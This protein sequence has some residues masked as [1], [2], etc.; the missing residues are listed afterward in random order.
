M[1]L[2]GRCKCAEWRAST[3]LRS[4][5]ACPHRCPL[6]LACRRRTRADEGALQLRSQAVIAAIHTTPVATLQRRGV[7][8]PLLLVEY[9]S[10]AAYSAQNGP[11]TAC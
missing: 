9:I 6:L 7:V 4:H 3:P 5:A 11:K 1:V 8:L 10:R 2:V